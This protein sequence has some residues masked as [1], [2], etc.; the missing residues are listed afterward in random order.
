MKYLSQYLLTF[1]IVTIKQRQN[2]SI[3]GGWINLLSICLN[4]FGL[5]WEGGDFGLFITIIPKVLSFLI[6]CFNNFEDLKNFNCLVPKL[7]VPNVS[8][9][10]CNQW[11]ILCIIIREWDVHQFIGHCFIPSD[12]GVSSY[13][14]NWYRQTS[15]YYLSSVLV[16][17]R[18][19]N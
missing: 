15:I 11:L 3:I 9:T 17:L 2:F 5:L 12:P 14:S 19:S 7:N 1:I 8:I 4:L 6:C 18:A 16:N 10:N 13:N